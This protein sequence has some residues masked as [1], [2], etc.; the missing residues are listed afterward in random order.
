MDKKEY[1]KSKIEELDCKINNATVTVVGGLAFDKT[2]IYNG[3]ELAVSDIIE[4]D[5]FKGLLN[6]FGDDYKT[7]DE[8][9]FVRDEDNNQQISNKNLSH[10]A[11]NYKVGAKMVFLARQ[12]KKRE[13]YQKR[14]QKLEEKERKEALEGKKGCKGCC[15]ICIYFL[16]SSW[17][18]FFLGSFLA[19]ITTLKT[20]SVIHASEYP[21]RSLY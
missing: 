6:S 10:I 20:Y 16:A 5:D 9:L 19:S 1:F 15:S 13:D 14:L 21:K 2:T 7:Y 18:S 3:E 8:V 12:M 11:R 17:L 4:S